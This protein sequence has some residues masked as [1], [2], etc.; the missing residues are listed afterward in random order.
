MIKVL[1]IKTSMLFN[2]H[3][4]NNTI[5]S[6]YFVFLLIIDLYLLFLG[7]TAQIINPIAE[8]VIPIGIPIKKAK[9]EMETVIVE[10]AISKWSINS[11]NFFMVLT[12]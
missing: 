4:A 9:A 5:L 2:L 1:E 8:L 12:Y 11:A 7:V 3:L 6:C 10:I